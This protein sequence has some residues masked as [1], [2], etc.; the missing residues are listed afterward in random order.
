MTTAHKGTTYRKSKCKKMNFMIELRVIENMEDVIPKGERSSF[1]NE[2]LE[3][4]LIR[5]QRK[6]AFRAMDKLREKA[7]IRITDKEIRKYR[8]YGRQ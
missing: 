3:E 5:K 2:V 8:N 6:N 7:N 1:V 4:A